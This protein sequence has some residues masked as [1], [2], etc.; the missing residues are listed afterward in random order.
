MAFGHDTSLTE[1]GR[2]G[3]DNPSGAAR[4]LSYASPHNPV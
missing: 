2:T 1:R 4:H 3:Y